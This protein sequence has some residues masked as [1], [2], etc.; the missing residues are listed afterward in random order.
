[1]VPDQVLNST[2]QI[3]LLYIHTLTFRSIYHQP[4]QI[5]VIGSSVEL[6]LPSQAMYSVPGSSEPKF[7]I[8]LSSGGIGP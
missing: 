2:T 6:M 7:F 1:M 3:F 4:V 8:W 5:K